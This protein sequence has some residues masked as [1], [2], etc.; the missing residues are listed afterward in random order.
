MAVVDRI[1]ESD[2][3]GAAGDTQDEVAAAIGLGD[4]D[5][6]GRDASTKLEHVGAAVAAA[7]VAPFGDDIL[8][9]AGV[10]HI[11]VVAAVAAKCVVAGAAGQRVVAGPAL[12]SEEHTSELQ[13]LMRSPYA[14]F[15][16]KKK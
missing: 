10:E 15:C 3:V 9:V 7:A 8:A 14:V 1:I 13:S 5:V 12:R 4:G 16:L 6:G 11:G 2:A